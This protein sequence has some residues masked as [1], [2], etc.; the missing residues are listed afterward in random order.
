M[1]CRDRIGALEKRSTPR[2]SP[3]Q[4]NSGQQPARC[5]LVLSIAPPFG[6]REHTPLRLKIRKER[7]GLATHDCH[8]P[9]EIYISSRPLPLALQSRPPPARGSRRVVAP[10]SP[11]GEIKIDHCDQ[12]RPSAQGKA[13][14]SSPC[15]SSFSPSAARSTCRA[16]FF[17]LGFFSGLATTNGTRPSSKSQGLLSLLF[18]PSHL[19]H[20]A[21]LPPPSLLFSG[22]CCQSS[23]ENKNQRNKPTTETTPAR[24]SSPCFPSSLP[25]QPAFLP[26]R[27]PPPAVLG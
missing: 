26:L 6:M 18:F 16:L 19:W 22:S 23:K 4:V 5:G 1:E 10:S 13:L 17:P 2:S 14:P 8:T 12:T 11:G 7:M 9:L 27:S 3:A 15:S 20:K 25:R 21:F 24:P